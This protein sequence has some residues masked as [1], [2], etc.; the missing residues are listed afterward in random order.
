MW[1]IAA[2]GQLVPSGGED[3]VV[4]DLNAV[5]GLVWSA[6]FVRTTGPR[7]AEDNGNG[8]NDGAA[9]V[10]DYLLTVGGD[11]A[12]LWDLESGEPKMT[13]GRQG[14]VASARFSP[15][16]DHVVTASWDN[17]A[18]IWDVDSG[19][20][21]RK[22][23]GGHLGFVNSAAYS[24]DGSRIVT[25]SDD[26]TIKIWDAQSGDVL[27][28][29]KGHEGGVRTAV[30]SPDGKIVLSASDDK[31]A[32]IWD[33]NTGECRMTLSGHDQAVLAA[34]FSPD[35]EMV[36]TAGEDNTAR[37]WD[38][39]TGQP[40]GTPKEPEERAADSDRDHGKDDRPDDPHD[41]FEPLMLVGHTAAVTAVAFSPTGGRVV[42][43][44]ADGTAI[45]WNPRTGCELLTLRGHSRELT[46]ALFAPDGSSIFTGSRDG[47]GILWMAA[48]WSQ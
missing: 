3:N 32:R 31:T 30:F 46:T 37:L 27:H 18:R 35:G 29:L 47:T 4:A 34:A 41:E 43:A 12:R 33:S 25:A 40:I 11:E 15:S 16:G 6:A 22:L 17:A 44:S 14:A 21:V 8:A 7:G 28:E 26:K 19:R 23:A 10:G 39:K 38:A 13:F 1:D 48:E 20:S 9:R 5:G 36:V 24:P 42:T 2:D 45:V